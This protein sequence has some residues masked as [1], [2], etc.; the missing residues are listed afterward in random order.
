MNHAR[1]W[2]IARALPLSCRDKLLRE[3]RAHARPG[4]VAMLAPRRSRVWRLLAGA[5][6]LG[7]RFSE[8]G[9]R[10]FGHFV[11][12]LPT[13]VLQ[14]DMLDRNRIRV[15]IEIRHRLIF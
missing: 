4:V 5:C 7:C 8:T 14:F 15:G 2:V 11:V 6:A 1:R 3:T 12:A 13:L 10:R 9:L